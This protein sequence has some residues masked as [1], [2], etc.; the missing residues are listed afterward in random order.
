MAFTFQLLEQFNLLHVEAKISA[1]DYIGYIRR[2]S[3]NAFTHQVTDPYSQFRLVSRVWDLLTSTKRQGHYH[4]LNKLLVP[5]GRQPDSLVVS[6]PACPDPLINMDAKWRDTPQHLRHINQF[7]WTVDGNFHLNKYMKNTDPD[8]ISLY[9]GKAYFPRNDEYKRYL[10]GIPINSKEKVICDHLKAMEKQNRKK[11]K[12]MDVTGVVQIQCSHVMVKSTVDLQLGERFANTD[13]AITLAI[14][15]YQSGNLTD[16][17]IDIL[18]SYDI[19]CGYCVNALERFS[20]NFED[21]A[22]TVKKFRWLIPLLH[23]Q[24]HKNDSEMIWA[25]SNQLGAQTRQMNA[26]HRHNT[27]INVMSDWNWKKVANM[28]NALMN[29][30][31]KAKTLYT[32]K[33]DIMKGLTELYAEKVPLWNQADRQAQTKKPGKEIECVYRQRPQKL[34]S[35]SRVYELMLKE[36]EKKEHTSVWGTQLPSK[37]A[38][39]AMLNNA[40]KIG[41]LQRKII[42]KLAQGKSGKRNT[43]DAEIKN[44]RQQVLTRIERLRMSQKILTPQIEPYLMEHIRERPEPELEKLYLPSDFDNIRNRAMLGLEEVGEAQRLMVEG[45]ANDAIQRV[46]S[47]AKTLSNAV[48]DKKDNASG[49]TQQTR[50]TAT[51]TELKFWLDLTI[52]DY[53]ALRHMLINLGM[54]TADTLYRELK[55][56]DTFRKPAGAKHA[57]GDTY[58]NDGA[59]WTNT[60][61]TGGARA[62]SG[63]QVI[64]ESAIATQGTRAAKRKA[65]SPSPQRSKKSKTDS[66]TPKE[67][68]WI[69]LFGLTPTNDV[70]SE[71][72]QKWMDEEDRVQWFRAEAEM[73][74]WREELEIRQADYLR[75]IRYFD[76]MSHIWMDAQANCTPSSSIDLG[77]RAYARKKSQMYKDMASYARDLLISEGYGYLLEDGKAL[78]EHMDEFRSR[79]ENIMAYMDVLTTSS[80]GPSQ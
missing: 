13:Y 77:K 22:D 75:C 46:Q 52:E 21:L 36:D 49:Q 3:D 2:L 1:Y 16:D 59:V 29:D 73:L 76:T 40:L 72:L 32:Q 20:H 58:W 69:W 14:R 39:A 24:N 78:H 31:R 44:D 33:R 71:D 11:F 42:Q 66:N 80:A 41:S 65:K 5:L 43:T 12:N 55:E 23:V 8:D 74:R 25:E 70:S 19:S 54:P 15:Q 4:D 68:G 67:D 6:C 28:A 79:P 50:A 30:I 37:G 17:V 47:I 27:I 57:L 62:P 48:K 7:Q 26:G 51:L 9:D 53:N 64:A 18:L 63:S 61:V 56:S 35:Q 34:L 45:A 60:G 10:D 38:V